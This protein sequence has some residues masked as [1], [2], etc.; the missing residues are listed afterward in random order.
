M[1][2]AGAIA[3]DNKRMAIL[4][5]SRLNCEKLVEGKPIVVDLAEF[6]IEGRLVLV[7]GETEADITRELAQHFTLPS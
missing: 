2:K 1:V 3:S 7:G 4:G 5:L 6:G